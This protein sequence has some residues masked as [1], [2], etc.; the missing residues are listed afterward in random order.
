M[1][2]QPEAEKPAP[3]MK[4]KLLLPDDDELEETPEHVEVL[5]IVA[6][7][8][9]DT[10]WE[11]EI[12]KRRVERCIPPTSCHKLNLTCV[13][14]LRKLFA[15]DRL[16][17]KMEEAIKVFD[18]EVE[19]V[20]N[21]KFQ[22]LVDATYIDLHLLTLHQELVVLKEFESSE[23]LLSDKV[24]S[25]MEDLLD[26]KDIITDLNHRTEMHKR[27][28]EHMQVRTNNMYVGVSKL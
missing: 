20:Y 19:A 17:E 15:Q 26:L 3:Q 24:H 6:E 10:E 2:P 25:V 14:F 22:V 28:I 21:E 23:D 1:N 4:P 16:I 9:P 5:E 8:E 7:P 27:E 11:S 18:D 12:R 13:L